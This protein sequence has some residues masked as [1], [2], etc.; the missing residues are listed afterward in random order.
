MVKKYMKYTQ[1][2]I[3][4]V[5]AMFRNN[6]PNSIIIRGFKEQFK[7][8]I[9]ARQ[10]DYM[11]KEKLPS[12]NIK[13]TFSV[14]LV[15]AEEAA[16][17]LVKPIETKAWHTDT[18]SRKQC[19][20]LMALTY[21]MTDGKERNSMTKELYD[22]GTLTKKEAHDRIHSLTV[23]ME[24]IIHS[25]KLPEVVE[26]I[27]SEVIGETTP[28][29]IEEKEPRFT[30]TRH[31]WSD[32]EELDLLCDFYELSIDEA[33]ERFQRPFYAIAKRLEKIVDSTE[34]KHI[35]MLMEATKVI[36]ERK[37]ASHK[38]AKN[39]FLKRRKVR[40][41]AKKLLKLEKKLSKLRGE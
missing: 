17:K 14:N 24:R 39:G 31:K 29:V 22:S 38:A 7:E 21:P 18:A 27:V 37:R 5:H 10:I 1:K 12:S 26:T 25:P 9:N 6:F 2:K 13:S 15:K 20:R 11:M 3:D 41:Q 30:R 28:E 19:A 34:P 36:K 33:R 23:Q 40:K 4:F 16:A 35:N 8:S 32:K